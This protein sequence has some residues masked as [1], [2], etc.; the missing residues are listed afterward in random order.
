MTGNAGAFTNWASA[1]RLAEVH[2]SYRRWFGP[3]Y[4]MDALDAVLSARAS[5]KLGGDPPWLLM[6]GGSGAA[7]TE[8]IMPL[9]GTGAVVVSALSGEAALLSGTAR[10]ERAANASGGLLRRTGK[11]GV[12]VI[13]DFT[14][15]L[16]MNR[17]TRAAILA[18]LREIHDGE[19]SREVG[20]DGGQVLRW[21]GRLVLIGAVT[22]AWDSA[23]GVISAMGDRFILVRLDS[24]ITSHRRAAGRQAMANVDHEGEMRA[25]LSA[26]V[27]A[28]MDAADTDV[29]ALD[30]ADVTA[31]LGLADIV[32]R[33]RTPVERDYRGDPVYAHEPEMPTRFAKELVQIQRG[34]MALGMTGARP[35]EL[36][37]RCARDSMLPL[38]RR[39]LGAVAKL[40]DAFT[41]DVVRVLQVP[42]VTAER[43]LQELHL[44][45]FLTVADVPYG[46]GER[47]RWCYSIADDVDADDLAILTRK[48]EET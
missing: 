18:A 42:R 1:D 37:V 45:G 39:C 35:R 2:D 14:T 24:K 27:G 46:T 11:S 48:D 29:P 4:D 41:A 33:A 38:R 40:K 47:H 16:S 36:A 15:I 28:L 12:L 30:A 7:K 8:T 34:A 3:D 17:D 25:E 19:W 23:Y 13:K 26:A 43:T 22:T 6:V 32:T 9:A 31:L 44:L 21:R 20:S 5:E 10:K